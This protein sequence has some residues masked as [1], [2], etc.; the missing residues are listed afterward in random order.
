MAETQEGFLERTTGLVV[1]TVVFV[2]CIRIIWP[3]LGAIIWSAIIVVATWPLHLRLRQRFAS[4]PKAA[5]GIMT[6]GLAVVLLGPVLL[7]TIS[8]SE[9]IQSATTLVGELT[10]VKLEP[11][12]PAWVAD[13][14][15][16]SDK[17]TAL[18]HRAA[19]DMEGLASSLRP[20]I[21]S[22]ARWLLAKG[23][24]LG[25]AALELLLVLVI[26]ALL[27][28]SGET[29]AGYVR[30]FA[31]RVGGSRSLHSLS[32]AI[33]T[34]RG[35]SLG[36]IG[37]AAIQAALSAIGFWLADVPGWVLLS[38]ICFVSA[39]LQIGTGVVWIPVAAWLFYHDAQGWAVFTVVWG[40]F[41]NTIDNFIK[42]YLISQGSG[43]PMA[44]IFMGVLGGLLTWGFIGIFLGPTL[45]ATG[46]TLLKSWLEQKSAESVT[47]IVSNE[48]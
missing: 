47:P 21:G 20:Q 31:E 22:A 14:P 41:I 5:T 18:W 1:L 36:V 43:L 35:V 24:G 34:I 29:L 48:L 13:V 46:Y 8:L 25:L 38:C 17:L 23:A 9:H 4:R 37:T 39:L 12:P 33:Q 10:Q 7:L 40:I 6:A 16:I 28:G 19:T 32:I 44:L 11:E 26:S 42:P 30:S 2:A 3:F 15:I 45:L 27:Y